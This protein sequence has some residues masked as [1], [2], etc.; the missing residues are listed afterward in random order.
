MKNNIS[1]VV[2]DLGM[3]LIPFDYNI[4][5]NKLDKIEHGLGARYFK[6]YQEN[7][8]VYKKY[9]KWDLTDEE[10]CRIN[11][12]WL[13]NKISEEE[14]KIIWSDIFLKET[15]LTSLLPELKENYKLVLMSNTCH[16]HQ[17]YGW[18]KYDFLKY[19]DKLI[20]S[21]EVAAY[22]PMKEIYKSVENYTKEK[23]ESHLYIDDVKEYVDAAEK[24]GWNGIHFIDED[25]A[26]KKVKDFLEI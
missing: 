13:D 19:F 8:D 7:I 16:I 10:F 15:K 4:M 21:H 17:K 20:L 25:D 23:S 9:E 24:L 11:L 26:Y 1:T 6:L 14:F 3:V 2:F 22:K 12:N 18:E 5:L